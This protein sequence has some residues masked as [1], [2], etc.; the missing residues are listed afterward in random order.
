MAVHAVG[1]THALVQLIV[2]VVGTMA[3]I[4]L[5]TV[6]AN[7]MT[8]LSLDAPKEYLPG[9]KEKQIFTTKIPVAGW[10][11]L[12]KAVN[13]TLAPSKKTLLLGTKVSLKKITLL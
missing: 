3:F 9:T 4:V 10:E 8:L 13:Q 7:D 11:K 12:I 5:T 6:Y 1:I 2:L